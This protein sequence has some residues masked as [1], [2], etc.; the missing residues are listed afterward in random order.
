MRIL[1]VILDFSS[2]IQLSF[3]MAVVCWWAFGGFYLVHEAIARGSLSLAFIKFC[4]VAGAF[5]ALGIW[6]GVT[7]FS[8]LEDRRRAK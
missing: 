3:G 6:V 2:M 1:R 8:W 5:V 4:M 7:G